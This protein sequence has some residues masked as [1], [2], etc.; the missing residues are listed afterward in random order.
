[1]FANNRDMIS[2]F[3]LLEESCERDSSSLAWMFVF[4]HV[5]DGQNEFKKLC[6]VE[7]VRN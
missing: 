1:M 6:S 3:E 7:S 2:L 5:L 4:E